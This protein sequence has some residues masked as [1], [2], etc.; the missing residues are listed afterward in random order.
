[1]LTLIKTHGVILLL[2]EQRK[3]S[4]I[5]ETIHNFLKGAIHSRRC[6]RS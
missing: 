2:S 1:M 5:K 6:S 3:L 4:E